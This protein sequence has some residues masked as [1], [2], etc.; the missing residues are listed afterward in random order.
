MGNAISAYLGNAILAYSG[1][2][3]FGLSRCAFLKLLAYNFAHAFLF[4]CL[5]AKGPSD[6]IL[7]FLG[8]LCNLQRAST[9][10]GVRLGSGRFAVGWFASRMYVAMHVGGWESARKV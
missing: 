10:T 6:L 2:G 5:I 7:N 1:N 3:V 9:I 4:K 8:A